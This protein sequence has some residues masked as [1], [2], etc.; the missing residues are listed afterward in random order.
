MSW[1]ADKHRRFKESH[2]KV[3]LAEDERDALKAEYTDFVKELADASVTSTVYAEC[4]ISQ[5]EKIVAL[6]GPM[7]EKPPTNV[8]SSQHSGWLEV[9]KVLDEVRPGW[10]NLSHA[11]LASAVC[12]IREL[13]EK[14]SA[15]VDK[16]PNEPHAELRKTWAPGQEWQIMPSDSAGAWADLNK[17]CE[18]MWLSKLA[19]RRKPGTF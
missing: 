10:V 16:N 15:P 13:A 17:I 2:E 12:A 4:M 14:H 11:G 8:Q 6:L 18:P 5:A 19:Y 9:V 1:D 7:V 3:K